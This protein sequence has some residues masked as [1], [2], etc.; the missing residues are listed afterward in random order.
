MINFK[1]FQGRLDSS[2]KQLKRDLEND[3]RTLDAKMLDVTL[4]VEVLKNGRRTLEGE[5]LTKM[6]ELIKENQKNLTQLA[7]MIDL[8]IQ[9]YNMIENIQYIQP[10]EPVNKEGELA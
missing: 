7:N 6:D 3:V 9:K 2:K 4:M 8:A 5:D 1:D 10:E